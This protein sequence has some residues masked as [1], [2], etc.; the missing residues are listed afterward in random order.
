MG[1]VASPR[2]FN[3]EHYRELHTLNG[4]KCSSDYNSPHELRMGLLVPVYSVIHVK[5]S[6]ALEKIL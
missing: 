4:G 3:G 6:I 5:E 1:L 2:I